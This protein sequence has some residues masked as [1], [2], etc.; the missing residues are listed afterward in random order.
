MACRNGRRNV[1]LE[2]RHH[3]PPPAL[4]D[5]VQDKFA[6]VVEVDM[7]NP[8]ADDDAPITILNT[9]YVVDSWQASQ[10]LQAIHRVHSMRI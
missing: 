3:Q 9:T 8:D 5:P 6:P 4:F 7:G 10:E 1:V 2:W